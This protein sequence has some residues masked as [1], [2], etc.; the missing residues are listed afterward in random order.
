VYKESYLRIDRDGDGIA[1]LHRVCQ[2]GVNLLHAEECDIIPIASYSGVIV[3]HQHLGLSVYDL[4]ED[5][6][7]IKTALMRSYLDNRYLQ[8]NTRAAVDVDRV[9][10]DDFLVSRPGGV[11]RVVGDPG[12]AIMPIVAPDTS[13]GALQ[14][15]EYLDTVRENRTGY[16]RNSAGMDNDA[17][18]NKT[19]SGMAMQLSQSQLR[20]EMIA[21]TIAETGVRDTFRIIHAL[22][23]KHS[24]KAEKVK[25]KGKW[26]AVNPREWVQRHSLSISIGLGTGTSEQQLA[27]L[28]AL[29]PLM[30]QG[31]AMGLV[32]VKEGYNYTTE[33]FKLS[34]Y[35]SP[36][37]FVHP[38]QTDPQTGEPVAPPPQKPVEVQVEEIRQQ[39][40][41]QKF[42]AESAADVEKFH[43]EQ[44]GK[45]QMIQLEAQ[46]KQQEQQAQLAVQAANDQRQAQLD[47]AN[48]AREMYKI[49]LE[50]ELEREKMEREFAFKQWEAQAR[51]SAESQTQSTIARAAG[52]DVGSENAVMTALAPVL[53]A[54]E[55]HMQ[56]TS[57]AL[58]STNAALAGLSAPKQVVR[59]KS[60]RVVGVQSI[61]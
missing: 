55:Q 9:N 3:P 60:G 49:N 48:N 22:T 14:G 37:R 42:Q 58:A 26:V 41:A 59:D 27:K 2:V 44:A 21:R 52:I 46:A 17:L 53:S 40:A 5:L 19:A 36:D 32:G 43:A 15:L 45:T 47:A 31:Q 34:G 24:S 23:L 16:T 35:K 13:S 56:A 7:K 8:N 61:Q 25:L 20:L 33:A 30:Q 54:M 29:A 18:T 28:M 38:P 39:G 1:T 12:S 11:I 6:A 4:V 50:A 51:I 57:A 10:V